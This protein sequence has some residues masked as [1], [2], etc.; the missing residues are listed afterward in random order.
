MS[1]NSPIS[2]MA[3]WHPA[4][5]SFTNPFPEAQ[6]G[7]SWNRVGER[8]IFSNSYS[9][10]THHVNCMFRLNS[11]I[12]R[13]RAVFPCLGFKVVCCTKAHSGRI[14]ATLNNLASH[15]S[16]G[17]GIFSFF[18]QWAIN[19]PTYIH[20]ILPAQRGDFFFLS[21]KMYTLQFL[22]QLLLRLWKRKM[23][24][25]WGKSLLVNIYWVP[26]AWQTWSSRMGEKDE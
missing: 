4:G 5:G 12:Q 13:A 21:I 3:A 17:E 2:T 24:L 26:N 1:A 25:W 16:E 14:R 22:L 19:L 7:C 15:M 10:N 11:G 6:S 8:Q 9:T 18:E 20:G 23:W